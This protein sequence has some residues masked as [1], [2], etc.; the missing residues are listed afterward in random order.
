[1]ELSTKKGKNGAI[2]E[3]RLYIDNT[4]FTFKYDNHTRKYNVIL[5][6]HGEKWVYEGEKP[7]HSYS[8]GKGDTILHCLKMMKKY[9]RE[10]KKMDK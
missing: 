7:I 4:F 2:E 1:M 10:T 9:M 6:Q 5:F 3:F 8:K